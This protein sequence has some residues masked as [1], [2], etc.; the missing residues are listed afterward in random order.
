[1]L[2]NRFLDE[3]PSYEDQLSEDEIEDVVHAVKLSL[4]ESERKQIYM[5]DEES[6]QIDEAEEL[7]KALEQSI[8]SSKESS[9]STGCIGLKWWKVFKEYKPFGHTSKG[10]SSPSKSRQRRNITVCDVCEEQIRSA[11]LRCY[12]GQTYCEKHISDGTP[13]CCS[14]YRLKL[15][16]MKYITLSDGR[17]L[18]PDCRHTAV[19]DP[20]ECKPLLNEVHRFFKGLNMEIRCYIPVLL[21]DEEEMIRIFNKRALGLTTFERYRFEARTYVTRS[22]QKGDDVEVV[23]DVYHLL[24]GHRVTSIQLLYG[25]PKLALGAT[26]AHEMMHAWMQIQGYRGGIPLHIE[27][28]IC[29]VMSHKWIEWH[30]FVGDEFMNGTSEEA[31]FLR[32]LKEYLKDRI[33]KNYN[34]TYGHGFREVKW[35]VERYGL[36]Y[37]MKHIVNTGNLPQ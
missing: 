16:D 29:E 26:L 17:K 36:R 1:M 15:G 11:W 19:M 24:P 37:T 14:C 10:T 31:Q 32:H 20:E 7:A 33:E 4:Q 23:K 30:A 35:A 28:G 27:E 3:A 21:V 25:Y 6:S 18:C 9:T 12:W 2:D 5:G 22:I 34:E 8:I 13:T